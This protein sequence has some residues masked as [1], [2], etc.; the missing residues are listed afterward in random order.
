MARCRASGCAR[1]IS[2]T[3]LFCVIH[4]DMLPKANKSKLMDLFEAGK[5]IL[6]QNQNLPWAKAAVSAIKLLELL[7]AQKNQIKTQGYTQ[8]H[9][10]GPNKGPNQNDIMSKFKYEQVDDQDDD[11]ADAGEDTSID[12]DI[13]DF[14]PPVDD[15]NKPW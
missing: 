10:H 13:P 11:D 6:D 5:K 12:L 9:A 3:K 4:W 8:G 1:V 7:E 14:E 2:E 15:D